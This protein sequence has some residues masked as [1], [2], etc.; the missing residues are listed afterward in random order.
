[1]SKTRKIQRK[2]GKIEAKNR[3][4]SIFRFLVIYILLMGAAVL[5]IGYEPLKRII[6]L[7]GLYTRAVVSLTTRTLNFVGVRV[8][9]EGGVIHLP[10]LALQ[11]RFGCNGLEAFLIYSVAVLAFPAPWRS[12]LTGIL[13]GG[14]VIQVLNILRLIGLGLVGVYLPA[15][16]EVFHIY[17][18]QGLMIAVALI[19]FMGWLS[20]AYRSS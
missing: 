19:L 7:N 9:Q 14:V 20:H 4:P 17:V 12:K 6:D 2:R 18:A 10:G 15:W 1:V 8:A 3:Q 11:V 5:L 16:F 13:L